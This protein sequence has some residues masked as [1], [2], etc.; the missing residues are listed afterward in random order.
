MPGKAQHSALECAT[1]LAFFLPGQSRGQHRVGKSYGRLVPLVVFMR[2]VPGDS[3]T[4]EE[5]PRMK[6]CLGV[7]RWN[8]KLAGQTRRPAR[9]LSGAGVTGKRF[10]VPLIARVGVNWV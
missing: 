2:H 10:G 7:R 4:S 8:V 6:P 1:S 3:A 9:K 5:C